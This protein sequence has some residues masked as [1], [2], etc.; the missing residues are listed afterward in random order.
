[1]KYSVLSIVYKFAPAILLIALFLLGW[2]S[3]L[4]QSP[5]FDEPYHVSIGYDTWQSGHQRYDLLHTSLSRRW[6][7]LPLLFLDLKWPQNSP[8]Q[9]VLSAEFLF[10]NS[11]TPQV[12]FRWIT[13]WMALPALFLG[14]GIYRLVSS[15]WG[16]PAGL[17]ALTF[18]VFDPNVLAHS[19]LATTD[20]LLATTFFWCVFLFWQLDQE[21]TVKKAFLAGAGLGL[22]LMSKYSAI[23]LVPVL[24][25]LTL[26]RSLLSRQRKRFFLFGISLL[27]AA[28][29][30]FIESGFEWISPL[31]F[32]NQ[33]QELQGLPL[34]EDTGG[35]AS[36]ALPFIRYLYGLYLMTENVAAGRPLFLLG[37]LYPTGTMAFFPITILLKTSL[38]VLI[39]ILWGFSL[40]IVRKVKEKSISFSD[41]FLVIPPLI[42]LISLLFSRLNLGYRHI[43]PLLPFLYLLAGPVTRQ[44][45]KTNSKLFLFGLIT[46]VLAINLSIYPYYLGYFNQLA[47]GPSNGYRYLVESNLD[48]GQELPR[49]AQFQEDNQTGPIALAYFGSA[50]PEAYGLDY[51]CL[52]SYGW[53]DCPEN[54]LPDSGWVAVSATCLQGLCT[55]NP[56][57]YAQLRSRQPDA[58]IGY[59]IFVYNLP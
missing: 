49:L 52:P 12:I 19:G 30:I 23:I 9:G 33:Q 13:S 44:F 51:S 18:F 53:L 57:F 28:G 59:S 6:I 25:I 48:W 43:L 4:G 26:G 38:P 56:D 41:L 46:L 27:T 45:Q 54:R 17:V 55:Q 10:N 20:I 3:K 8:N 47:G 36:V 5:S 42:F 14:W 7:S 11:V 32:A 2:I 34:I 24:L 22:A 29:L 50:H 40:V 31:G 37:N 15:K 35:L 58:V 39:L 21:P 16:K 1:M